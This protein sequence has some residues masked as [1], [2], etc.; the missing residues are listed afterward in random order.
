MPDAVG[1]RFEAT[2]GSGELRFGATYTGTG[3]T[4]LRIDAIDDGTGGVIA[5]ATIPIV[6]TEA[7]P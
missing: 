4:S 1:L 6:V 3:Q 7:T 5:T 2:D